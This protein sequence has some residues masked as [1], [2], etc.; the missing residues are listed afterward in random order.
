MRKRRQ[1]RNIIFLNTTNNMFKNIMFH[2][3][4]N[5]KMLSNL[6]MKNIMTKRSTL[7][8]RRNIRR[9]MRR[10]LMLPSTTK[11]K[12]MLLKN[13]RKKII[14]NQLMKWISMTHLNRKRRQLLSRK[15]TTTKLR[16]RRSITTK[17][18]LKRSTNTRNMHL[19]KK[20]RNKRRNITR[21]LIRK[22]MMMER[23]RR[24]LLR[25]LNRLKTIVSNQKLRKNKRLK[26]IK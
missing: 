6:N 1:P 5:R 23:K 10:R 19:L 22:N 17:L 21:N 16:L 11:R 26:S 24:K 2:M 4:N 3:I 14:S 12:L 25:K 13:T 20:P 7:S 15:N 18:N 9:N 8:M